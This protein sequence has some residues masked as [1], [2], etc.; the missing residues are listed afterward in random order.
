MNE[1]NVYENCELIDT[2]YYHDSCDAAEVYASLVGHDGYN[3][4]IEVIKVQN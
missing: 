1:W 3:P 4:D 2:V